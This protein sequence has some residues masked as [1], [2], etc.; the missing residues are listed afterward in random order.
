MAEEALR[1]S[2]EK[3]QA[4]VESIGD[5]IWELDPRGRYV[6][7]SPQIELILGYRPEE[8]IG[9]TPSETV[10]EEDV[11]ATMLIFMDRFLHKQRFTNI[12]SR[13][14]HK[15]GRVV[16]AETNAVPVLGHQGELTGY[17]GI[18]RDVTPRMVVEKA[19]QAAN[20]NLN[21]LNSIT[22]HDVS[23]QLTIINGYLDL[24]GT[25]VQEEKGTIYLAKAKRA[26][27][28]AQCATNLKQVVLAFKVWE[29][30]HGDKYPMAVST[31]SWGAMENVSSRAN[32]T[33]TPSG[34]YGLTNVF[35]V[36]SNDMNTP[37]I[38]YC[39]TDISI[40]TQVSDAPGSHT[41]SGTTVCRV[42]TNWIGFGPQNLSYF[43]EGDAQDKYA[44][45]IF[46]GDRNIGKTGAGNGVPA[47]AMDMVNG[48]YAGGISASAGNAV[49]FN[50]WDGTTK[51]W[52]WTDLDLHQDAGNLGMVDGSVQQSSL[53]GLNNAL[54]DTLS[55]WQT[56]GGIG[57]Y[58]NWILNMP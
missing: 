42:A 28:R 12:V 8:I 47:T 36:M 52:E 34:G 14:R 57:N 37:K 32:S 9:R 31:I 3:F 29:G 15:D 33:I 40:A 11:M 46:T 24:L 10:V 6:Y 22:R 5:F 35:C 1:E 49:K 44:K 13:H 2:K 17:R 38:L 25:A 56:T 58:P 48:S 53:G 43:V 54:K 4:L 50:A 23:N 45:M 39:P 20:D 27:R 26:A 18:D 30:D 21:L 19:L 41:I 16:Y 51:F 7:A 55:A